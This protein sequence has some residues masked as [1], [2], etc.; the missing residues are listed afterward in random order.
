MGN[1]RYIFQKFNKMDLK[2]QQ[3]IELENEIK[4]INELIN[5]KKLKLHNSASQSF[6]VDCKRD[7]ISKKVMEKLTKQ[8]SLKEELKKLK[9]DDSN[10]EAEQIS[11]R[12]LILEE[13]VN[14]TQE[15]IKNR[16]SRAVNDFKTLSKGTEDELYLIKQKSVQDLES[17]LGDL[18]EYKNSA[19]EEI[20]ALKPQKKSS[21]SKLVKEMISQLECILER[22]EICEKDIKT[23]VTVVKNYHKIYRKTLFHK[24]N[25]ICFDK[26]ANEIENVSCIDSDISME[27]ILKLVRKLDDIKKRF[28]MD[29]R[30]TSL[31]RVYLCRRIE[32]KRTTLEE[33]FRT[34]HF[35]ELP[36]YV[37]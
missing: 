37:G 16:V 21:E 3:I 30:L 31:K 13:I 10:P 35:G 25:Q 26:Y 20:N 22:F 36:M 11:A 34:Y 23:A 1:K 18:S 14:T 7:R 33:E 15:N 27:E 32:I 24:N 28:T 29:N 17:V 12:I 6:E 2:R 19:N 4:F 8:L 9:T 5:G